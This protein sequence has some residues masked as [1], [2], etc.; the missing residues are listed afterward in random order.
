MTVKQH[1]FQQ[2]LF[3]DNQVCVI[4]AGAVET[5]FH[6]NTAKNP[7]MIGKFQAGDVIGFAAS[8]RGITSNVQAWNICVSKVEAIW[9][10]ARDFEQL[11]AKQHKNAAKRI[12]YESLKLHSMFRRFNEN[13]LHML[14][15]ELLEERVFKHGVLIIPQHRRSAVNAQHVL[16]NKRQTNAILVSILEQR[17]LID[18]GGKDLAVSTFGLILKEVAKQAKD[19]IIREESKCS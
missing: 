12:F 4:L 16:F 14:A 5:T 9:M 17:K 18:S 15:F 3:T 1:D 2:Y 13:T 7:E 6:R 10:D 19:T 8:D 11:W